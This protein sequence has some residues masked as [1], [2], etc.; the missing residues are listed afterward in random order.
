VKRHKL[1]DGKEQ[2]QVERK[3]DGSWEENKTLNN[4]SRGVE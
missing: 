3:Q 2:K 1:I 4:K